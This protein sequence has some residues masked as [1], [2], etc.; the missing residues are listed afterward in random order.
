MWQARDSSK[1]GHHLP[2]VVPPRQDT[3]TIDQVHNGQAPFIACHPLE[4]SPLTQPLGLAML[5][6][7]PDILSTIKQASATKVCLRQLCCHCYAMHSVARIQH[8]LQSCNELTLHSYVQLLVYHIIWLSTHY[9]QLQCLP[10]ALMCL[11]CALL[12]AC[13]YFCV[14]LQYSFRHVGGPEV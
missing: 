10:P 3:V 7:H 6:S 4:P 1:N 11:L 8:P 2:L 14:I 13:C 9:P 12:L 5:T